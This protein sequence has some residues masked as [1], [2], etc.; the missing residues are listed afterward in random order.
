MKDISE[1]K[2]LD[3]RT[4]KN[5]YFYRLVICLGGF[6]YGSLEKSPASERKF[7]F[8]LGLTIF[9]PFLLAIG[10]SLY[11]FMRLTESW[12]ISIPCS[13]FIGIFVLLIDFASMNA[14]KKKVQ[15]NS[16]EV[17][18]KKSA[19]S[20]FF[21]F[22]PNTASR[23]NIVYWLLVVIRLVVAVLVSGVISHIVALGMFA[24]R[25][26]GHLESERDQEL[27]STRVE[28]D[29]RISVHRGIEPKEPSR[30]DSVLDE[31][32]N[33]L[34]LE[35]KKESK[36]SIINDQII[37]NLKKEV[38]KLNTESDKL[39]TKIQNKK[40]E[41]KR[42]LGAS[43]KK[44]KDADVE[45]T[46]GSISRTF[47]TGKGDTY[48]RLKANEEAFKNQARGAQKEVD[49]LV[50]QK[51]ELGKQVG[52]LRSA[53]TQRVEVI[54][55]NQKAE[56]EFLLDEQKKSSNSRL[57]REK[58]LASQDTVKNKV[59]HDNFVNKWNLWKK[60]LNGLESNK[61]KAIDK[62]NDTRKSDLLS[63]QEALDKIIK[64]ENGVEN[65]SLKNWVK[66]VFYFF[67]ALD[68]APLLLKAFRPT[69]L[70][71]AVFRQDILLGSLKL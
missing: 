34:D 56:E 28:Y 71:C 39:E 43:E 35:G 11:M 15:I 48:K 26:D 19:L 3:N 25:I 54:K 62:I 31:R 20:Q 29:N 32:K 33:L 42:L 30:V 66:A 12:F 55:T 45:R 8:S 22:I 40:D 21:T 69:L 1:D 23:V 52:Q 10:G 61:E 14:L 64:D 63:Q 46:T 44:G 24:N 13:L 53:R 37:I 51:K 18:F 59:N 9:I 60:Q 65:E 5:I 50:S 38:D 67:L 7:A 57:A 6:D 70:T 4:N 27:S 49:S 17:S 41:V 68:V 47:K 36:H 16:R 2:D 58:E